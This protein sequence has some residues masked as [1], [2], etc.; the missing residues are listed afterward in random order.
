LGQDIY[1]FKQQFFNRFLLN[2]GVCI[3][4]AD[5]FIRSTT[6]TSSSRRN[7]DASVCSMQ[8]MES[9]VN[10]WMQNIVYRLKLLSAGIKNAEWNEW[11]GFIWNNLVRIICLK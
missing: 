3:A 2:V 10:N 4:D 1:P 7:W 9:G 8:H 5:V 11:T 6:Q